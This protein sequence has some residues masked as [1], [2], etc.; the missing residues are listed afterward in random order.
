MHAGALSLLF[1][2]P[3]IYPLPFLLKGPANWIRSRYLAEVNRNHFSLN[4]AAQSHEA[5]RKRKGA[6]E[7]ASKH[8]LAEQPGHKPVGINTEVGFKG[9]RWILHGAGSSRD[10]PQ[11]LLHLF[12]PTPPYKMAQLSQLPHGLAGSQGRQ[13]G[14]Q[15]L[16]HSQLHSYKAGTSKSA[17]KWYN[18]QCRGHKGGIGGSQLP[19]LVRTLTTTFAA[20]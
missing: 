2:N 20:S 3:H 18:S 14:R 1:S 16:Q 6:I 10:F 8:K 11:R 9:A 15:P 13:A 4:P 5:R 17:W 19:A 7:K 12:S